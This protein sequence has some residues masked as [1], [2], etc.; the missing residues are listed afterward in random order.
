MKSFFGGVLVI[1]GLICNSANA[2]ETWSPSLGIKLLFP[3]AKRENPTHVH[4]EKI[5]ASLVDMSWLPSACT[6]RTHFYIEKTDTQVYSLLLAAMFAKSNVQVAVTD[7]EIVGGVCR[8][9]MIAS[10]TWN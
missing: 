6:N 10:P 9:T 1:F 2:T 4:S 3:Q 5:M 8:A 7:Q